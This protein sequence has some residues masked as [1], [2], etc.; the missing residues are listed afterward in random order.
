M[1]LHGGRGTV[2]IGLAEASPAV[3]QL[4]AAVEAL[5]VEGVPPVGLDAG[6]RPVADV[7]ALL[8]LLPRVEAVLGMRM[9]RAEAGGCL[10][11]LTAGG[12]A[13]HRWWSR[14][15]ARGLSRAGHLANRH[16]EIAAAWTAGTVTGEHVDAAAVGVHGLPDG[17]SDAVLAALDPLW[18]RTTPADVRRFC[19]RA[20]AI[21]DPPADP[22]ESAVRAHAQRFVSFAILD[23]TVHITGRLPRMEGELLMNTL[24]ATAESQRVAGDGVTA[25]QRRA[26]ALMVLAAGGASYAP[27]AV[28]ITAEGEALTS[29][30][31]LLTPGETR[32]ALCDPQL[33]TVLT[34]PSWPHRS[35]CGPPAGGLAAT[36]APPPSAPGIRGSRVPAPGSPQAGRP[37]DGPD[38]GG[39]ACGSEPGGAPPRGLGCGDPPRGPDPQR[40][41]AASDSWALVLAR[42]TAD[43]MAAPQPLAVGRTQRIATAAQRR[44]LALRDRGCIMPGCEVPAERCQIH[45]LTPWTEGGATDLPNLASLCWAHHRVVDLG[46]WDLLPAADHA[47]R[48][49]QS[50]GGE[51]SDGRE[52]A[53]GGAP[54]V[55]GVTAPRG[56]PANHGAPF[57]IRT[58]PRRRW[59]R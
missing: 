17:R 31:Y 56:T 36:G 41:A 38:P 10:P 30:G 28:T 12:M 52:P 7:A 21:V 6:D 55:A 54:A 23:D 1:E 49:G 50:E 24:H 15:R 51:P 27:I 47:S 3:V 37:P 34:A 4:A 20:R 59:G 8:E 22:D 11:F 46:R 14:S 2:A 42:V 57:T 33:T 26:D 32:H 25:T 9:A 29:G 19:A 35:A 45:H 39:G 53:D 16:P 18:G 5:V 48:G 58:R 44:A 13:S 40:L 43:T